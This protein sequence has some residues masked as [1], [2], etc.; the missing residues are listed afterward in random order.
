MYSLTWKYTGALFS[1]CSF[2]VSWFKTAACVQKIFVMYNKI[3]VSCFLIDMKYIFKMLTFY[4]A[5]LHHLSVP[6]FSEIV[7]MLGFQNS[8]INKN[9][10]RNVLRMFSMFL[11]VLVYPKIQIIGLG[12]S[13]RFKNPEII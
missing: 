12:L 4:Y 8:D 11:S 10:L 5:I 2:L 9:V 3:S 6:I 7:N 13:D 1:F